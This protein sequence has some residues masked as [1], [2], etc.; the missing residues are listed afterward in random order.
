[1]LGDVS[2]NNMQSKES[3]TP[4]L[5]VSV[6]CCTYNQEHY[7]RQC[8]EGLVMQKT[9]FKYEV[10]VHDDC[11]SD[12]TR[13]I[14]D[15]FASKYPSIVKPIYEKENQFTKR[16][17]SLERILNEHSHGKYIALCE[18][19]DYWIDEL[20]LQKQVDFLENHS[21]YVMCYGCCQYYYNNNNEF[22]SKAEGGPNESFDDLMR[23]NTIPTLTVLYRRD[24]LQKYYDD[25]RPFE[26]QWLMGDY[27]MFL[28][29]AHEGKIK[30]MKDIF[31]MYRVLGESASHSKDEN[32]AER[33]VYS[34][35]DII[36]FYSEYYNRPDLYKQ[37]NLYK[38]L[39]RNA[40]MFGNRQKAL[41]YYKKVSSPTK[42]MRKKA[43]IIKFPFLYH[44][45]K[46][47]K[48]RAIN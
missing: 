3:E 11:S 30:F 25:I 42:T 1:M 2:E 41:D 4:N 32:K 29:F 47:R 12:G 26:K 39:F 20:K 6:Q 17:G 16:D 18:G 36:R 24:M 31:A 23:T 21:D 13:F 38:A 28:Y 43:L 8:L 27:P 5:M 46:G 44:Y 33:F 14:I 7:I 48:F 45:F 15:E 9:T 35:Y 22:S 34:T 10:I 40:F 37:D 19:D